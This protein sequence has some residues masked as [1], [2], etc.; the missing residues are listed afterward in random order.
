MYLGIFFKDVLERLE[1]GIIKR[2]MWICEV[3]KGSREVDLESLDGSRR[4][5]VKEVCFLKESGFIEGRFWKF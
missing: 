3:R 1:I 2:R 4:K 5:F